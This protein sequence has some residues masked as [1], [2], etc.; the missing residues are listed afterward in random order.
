MVSTQSNDIWHEQTNPKVMTCHCSLLCVPSAAMLVVYG[1]F[2]HQIIS[3]AH[4]LYGW[5]LE[6]AQYGYIYQV[7]PNYMCLIS[8]SNKNCHT[9]HYHSYFLSPIGSIP[10]HIVHSASHQYSMKARISTRLIP[11]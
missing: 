1:G 4:V 5:I 6:F 9:T 8:H 7:L 11:I 3:A 2:P 10:I